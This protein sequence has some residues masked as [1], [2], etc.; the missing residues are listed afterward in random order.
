MKGIPFLYVFLFTLHAKTLCFEQS[1]AFDKLQE[2]AAFTWLKRETRGS[3]HKTL[4]LPSIQ[5]REIEDKKSKW[6]S[7]VLKMKKG[8]IQLP[9]T[10]FHFYD[11]S[12]SS[13]HRALFLDATQQ[14]AFIY[15]VWKKCQLIFLH[16]SA[17]FLWKSLP[18]P[19]QCCGVTF[20]NIE[21]CVAV[22]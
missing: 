15:A 22:E 2:S 17:A 16:G 7:L 11:Q 21:S 20:I 18:F 8:S 14:T 4:K 6:T 19:S 5:R 9:V 12:C 10:Y 3:I 1:E 13:T